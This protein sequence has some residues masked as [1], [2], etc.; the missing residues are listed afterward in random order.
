MIQYGIIWYDIIWLL[1]WGLSGATWGVLGRSWRS[2]WASCGPSGATLVAFWASKGGPWEPRRTKA[3][4]Y[5]LQNSKWN[6]LRVF[7]EFWWFR[8][9]IVLCFCMFFFSVM[10]QSKGGPWEPFGP[11]KRGPVHQDNLGQSIYIFRF[12]STPEA[13]DLQMRKNI[14]NLEKC[15]L[16][17]YPASHHF[18]KCWLY[19]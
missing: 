10:E 7:Y 1:T 2:F 13:V 14:I 5:L 19:F 16:V 17:S 4:Q 11:P 12:L 18:L 3:N 15:K 6:C 8:S 9:L